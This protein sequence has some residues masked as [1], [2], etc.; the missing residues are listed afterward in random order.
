MAIA[1]NA[2]DH[3]FVTDFKNKRIKKFRRDGRFLAAFPVQPHPGG[4]ALDREGLLYVAHWNDNK[5]GVY[6]SNGE[7]L[8]E[9]GKKGTGERE[10]RLPG[11]LAIGSDG[12]LLQ[13]IKATAGFRNSRATESFWSNGVSWGVGRA[14]SG[15]EPA[16]AHASRDR[17]LPWLPDSADAGDS[18][19][20]ADDEGIRERELMRGLELCGSGCTSRRRCGA[21]AP[22]TP[23]FSE[24]PSL[25]P[26]R[27]TLSSR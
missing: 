5:I 6:S 10:F 27:R 18:G 2:E 11:G 15:R 22:A 25:P 26:P 1:I 16:P 23:S 19:E 9:W 21:T 24:V 20:R 12:S 17:S 13:R 14:S 7:F 4:L 3:L 8:R